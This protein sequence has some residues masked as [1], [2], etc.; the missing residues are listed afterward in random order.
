MSVSIMVGHAVQGIK[1]GKF[2]SRKVKELFSFAILSLVS[3]VFIF[4]RDQND[5]SIIGV[6]VP[7]FSFQGYQKYLLD[8]LDQYNWHYNSNE[9][10]PGL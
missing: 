5:P 6:R 9:K 10:P 2:P 7:Y 4:L 3:Q 8:L 1:W